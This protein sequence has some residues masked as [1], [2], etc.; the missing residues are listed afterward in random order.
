MKRKLGRTSF[1]PYRLL[2]VKYAGVAW[3][4]LLWIRAKSKAQVEKMTQEE[5]NAAVITKCPL[6]VPGMC[7]PADGYPL[8]RHE[9]KR[10]EERDEEL[11]DNDGNCVFL[12]RY[13]DTLNYEC[14]L[15]VKSDKLRVYDRGY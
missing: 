1:G 12:L 13:A 9:C 4:P 10:S 8:V 7:F 14:R 6:D 11:S 2:S 15:R 3:E 5:V